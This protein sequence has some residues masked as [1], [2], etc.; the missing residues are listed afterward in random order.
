M[1]THVL[2]GI[3]VLMGLLALGCNEP[4]D[5]TEAGDGYE[6]Q[7]ELTDRIERGRYLVNVLGCT[8]CHSPKIMTARGPES[9]PDRFLSGHDEN[10]TLPGYDLAITKSFV[11]FNMNG[12]AVVGPWG[13]SFAANLTPDDTGI[14]TWSEAQFLKA[15]KEGKFKGL[16]GS[17]SLL[18]PMPWQSYSHMPNEDLKAVFAYLKSIKPVENVVPAAIAP[19]S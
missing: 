9:D 15:I 3:A 16:D 12:T 10:E 1:K 14:G 4:K 18:P 7:A 2:K 19:G 5:T 11:L 17:R 13:T 6:S 8:D